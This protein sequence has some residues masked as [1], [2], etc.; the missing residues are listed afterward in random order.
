M[1]TW[2][3]MI[4]A[5]LL[6]G[7]CGSDRSS[8]N[9]PVLCPLSNPDNVSRVHI[10]TDLDEE[11]LSPCNPSGRRFQVLV[12]AND[13]PSGVIGSRADGVSTALRTP[14]P[15]DKLSAAERYATAAMQT[16][17][18][19]LSTS[20]PA[21]ESCDLTCTIAFAYGEDIIRVSYDAV[22]EFDPSRAAN[23]VRNATSL[24]SK[25]SRPGS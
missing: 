9:K 1:K 7:A 21:F 3:W 15:R 8:T 11:D 19:P 23:I 18:R 6:I 20:N 10:A 22:G 12:I 24:L 4:G 13:R 16:A 17:W 14:I 2:L 25:S 5:S